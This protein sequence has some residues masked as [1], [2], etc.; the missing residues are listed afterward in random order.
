[1]WRRPPKQLGHRYSFSCLP[2]QKQCWLWYRQ[3]VRLPSIL[4]LP[5]VFQLC[6]VLC[7]F[8]A[9]LWHYEQVIAVRP[10]RGRHRLMSVC[11]PRA[12]W[13][14]IFS[15]A[16]LFNFK[17]SR[18]RASDLI[19]REESARLLSNSCISLYWAAIVIPSFWGIFIVCYINAPQ[20][21]NFHHGCFFASGY[22]PQ[23]TSIKARRL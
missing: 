5:V 2:V 16:A 1:M 19:L 6:A 3:R 15:D 12:F 23:L 4:L 9:L 8:H 20:Q 21:S 11:L 7:E 22:Q 13:H 17:V 10:Y 14:K 18:H